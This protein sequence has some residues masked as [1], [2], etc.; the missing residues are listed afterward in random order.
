MENRF[1]PF[2]PID[3]C[4]K[5]EPVPRTQVRPIPI[6][7]LWISEG[8]TQTQFSFKGVEFPGPKEGFPRDFPGTFDSSNVSRDNGSRRI[9]RTLLSDVRSASAL[10]AQTWRQR[11]A[12]RIII[13]TIS[14][15]TIIIII[16]IIIMMII[17]IIIIV[18]ILNI[19]III[20]IIIFSIA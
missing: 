8:L 7:T 11:G 13:I 14:I 6:L 19:I 4:R 16:I 10:G 18:I 9:G 2:A 12:P 1:L 17:I 15:I 20:V 5:P 3:F